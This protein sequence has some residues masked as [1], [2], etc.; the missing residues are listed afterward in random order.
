MSLKLVGQQKEPRRQSRYK[1]GTI[2]KHIVTHIINNQYQI[3]D[4]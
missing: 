4:L 2:R 1:H 3:R